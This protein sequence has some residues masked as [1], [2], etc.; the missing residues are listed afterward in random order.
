M[1]NQVKQPGITL[2]VGSKVN[3]PVNDLVQEFDR[4]I[5]VAG[6]KIQAGNLV[7]K[8][9]DPVPVEQQFMLLQFLF[10]IWHKLQT[11]AETA[12]Q[13]MLVDLGD[14]QVHERLHLV[15]VIAVGFF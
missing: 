13:E 3:F 2:Q 1:R 5:V 12:F 6:T 9:Q 8:H 11:L 4:F 15:V 10:H 14:I 7:I